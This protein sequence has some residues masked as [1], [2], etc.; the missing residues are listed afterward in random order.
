MKDFTD[1]SSL[2]NAVDT[3]LTH[4][5]ALWQVRAF[6]H[7]KLPWQYSHPSLCD[8]LA[9]LDENEVGAMEN[10][11]PELLRWLAPWLG[12]ELAIFTAGDRLPALPQRSLRT[13]ARLETG[14][15]GR[16]WA[17]VQAFAA[18]LPSRAR[19][20]LEWC[21]GKGHLGRLLALVDERDVVSLEHD[22]ALCRA[23]RQL[24][25]AAGAKQHF[26]VADALSDSSCQWLPANGQA[27]ALHAC[28]D[29]HTT[30][31]RFW[32]DSSCQRLTV[33]PCCF[34]LTAGVPCQALSAQASSSALRL[35]RVD[36]QWAVRQPVTGGAG[37]RRRR[38]IE[39]TWRL[40][41]D[42]WQRDLRGVDDYLP[43][44]SF[45]KSLLSGSFRHFCEWAA[46]EKG[47]TP[48][49]GLDEGYWLKRG[50]Q[51]TQSLRLIEVAGRP[52][53]RLLELWLILDRALFLQQGG[54]QVRIGTF[55]DYQL[56]PRNM[57]IDAV[58]A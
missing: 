12:D 31:M 29:L 35:N 45:P 44:P 15:G 47:L 5:R 8:A 41:F 46:N 22:E 24:A 1:L 36:L 18:I 39:L 54:A 57:V 2:F 25:R 20:I 55:C 50:A 38:Q 23:G 40:A 42:E 37:A 3:A 14:I 10:S 56:T 17:Q 11:P 30:L 32:T 51:R 48:N 53:Q 9:Q 34:H 7:R 16:K 43:L 13:P 33:A 19:P 52:F 4:H 28:G 26:V 21:S 27:V 58:K 6:H 49:P